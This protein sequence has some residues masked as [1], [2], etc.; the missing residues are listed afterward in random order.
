MNDILPPKRPLNQQQAP[1]PPVQP[2]PPVEPVGSPVPEQAPPQAPKKKRRLWLWVL[3][4][5]VA[6]IT[7]V[8]I[9]AVIWYNLSL[10]PVN[11]KDTAR[12]RIE[13]TEGM[14]PSAI[15]TLLEK[16]K[17]IRSKFAFDIYTRLSG[18]RSQLQAGS[19]TLSPSQTTQSIV[20]DIVSGR[21]NQFSLTFLPGATVDEDKAALVKSGYSKAEVDAAFNKTYDHPLFATKPASADLEGYIFGETYQF[22]GDAT[23]EQ[24][25]LRAF[26]EYY[27]VVKDQNL[28]AAFKKQG[29]TLY[30]GIT[31]ASIIQREVP[32]A[33]DQKQVAQIFLKRYRSDMTLG[34][35]ITAY[36]G[37]DKLGVE[38]TVAVDTPYNT[39]IHKGLPPGP[40]A[41]PGIT[42]LEAV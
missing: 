31:L 21:I 34:S 11:S 30:E 1:T 3:L 22:K 19:Y 33:T 15:G 10:Q 25:L 9:G 32:D 41:T 14:S 7:T 35:D 36:Y 23:V 4:S 2:R 20:A 13:I 38:R 39:R 42:A 8:A 16:D 17:L 29:L 40:I 24:I 6:L 26:D 12:T 5:V 27:K 28:V 18:T 37:A